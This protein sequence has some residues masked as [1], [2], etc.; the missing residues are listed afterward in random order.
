MSE[1][2]CNRCGYRDRA[3]RCNPT[4]RS[5]G[6]WYFMCGHRDAYTRCSA[7]SPKRLPGFLG[8]AKSG[9][10]DLDMK[11]SPRWCPLKAGDA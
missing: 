7:A 2:V 9:E 6:R 11:T 1:F 10:F 5:Y 4:Y 8:F 3:G